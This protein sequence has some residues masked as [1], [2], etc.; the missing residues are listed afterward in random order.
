MFLKKQ[1]IF[2]NSDLDVDNFTQRFNTTLNI[3]TKMPNTNNHVT[4]I[5]KLYV[6]YANK[7]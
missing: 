2:I 7:I 6:C 1:I 3:N 5:L 4:Q